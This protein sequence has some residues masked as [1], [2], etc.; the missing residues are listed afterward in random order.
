MRKIGFN[1]SLIYVQ[2]PQAKNTENIQCLSSSVNGWLRRLYSANRTTQVFPFSLSL[3][4]QHN[5]LANIYIFY[6]PPFNSVAKN[7]LWGRR[8]RHFLPLAP[9][10]KVTPMVKHTKAF[11]ILRYPFPPL[12]CLLCSDILLRTLFPDIINLRSCLYT[13]NNDV[14]C[15]YRIISNIH[16]AA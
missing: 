15:P 13:N 14:P 8:E 7:L 5:R 10:P 6:F 12:S 2:W 4:H 9:P 1:R 11:N 3:N 16:Y